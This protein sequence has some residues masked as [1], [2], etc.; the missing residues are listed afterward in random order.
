[1][2]FLSPPSSN[3]MQSASTIILVEAPGSQYCL[4]LNSLTGLTDSPTIIVG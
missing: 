3:W 1:M 4:T 2:T